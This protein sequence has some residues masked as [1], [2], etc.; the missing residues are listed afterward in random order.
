[1]LLRLYGIFVYCSWLGRMRMEMSQMVTNNFCTLRAHQIRHHWLILYT[2]FI[3]NTYDT[4]W[5]TLNLGLAHTLFLD[6][7]SRIRCLLNLVH[8]THKTLL[9]L[10]SIICLDLGLGPAL[11]CV[12]KHLAYFVFDGHVW[13][14]LSWCMD[15]MG[16]L[17][18]GNSW[19][20][21]VTWLDSE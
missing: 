15:V 21:L 7:Q 1:M 19:T 20:C 5:T 17:L 16:G 18:G 10:K 8:S 6:L 4:R 3:G 9:Q 14:N 12:P 13:L 11:K 2:Y